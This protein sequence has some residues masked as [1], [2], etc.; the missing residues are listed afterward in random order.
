MSRTA[1]QTVATDAKL[2]SGELFTLTYGALVLDL[3]H[4]LESAEEVCGIQE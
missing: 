2:M 4:D 1:K 3:I